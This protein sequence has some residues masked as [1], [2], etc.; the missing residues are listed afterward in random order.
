MH[1]MYKMYRI[2]KLYRIEITPK[3]NKQNKRKCN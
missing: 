1:K 2:N 3:L